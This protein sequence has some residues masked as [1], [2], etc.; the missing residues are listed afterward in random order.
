MK[1]RAA[2]LFDKGDDIAHDDPPA[3][4][5]TRRQGAAGAFPTNGSRA[6][7][8]RFPGAKSA[9]HKSPSRKPATKARMKACAGAPALVE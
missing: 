7:N 4:K 9:H 1:G 5:I 6:G 2:H 3:A 8:K